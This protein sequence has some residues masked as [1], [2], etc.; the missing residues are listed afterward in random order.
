MADFNPMFINDARL[1]T[2]LTERTSSL[3]DYYLVVAFFFAILPAWIYH[4]S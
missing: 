4:L 3:A 1:G 2:I